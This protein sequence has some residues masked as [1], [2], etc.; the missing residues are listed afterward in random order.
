MKC[1]TNGLKSADNSI[2]REALH[3]DTTIAQRIDLVFS[4]NALMPANHSLML[5]I[6]NFLSK[7]VHGAM[8][9]V[10]SFLL[11]QNL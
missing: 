5:Q 2:L 6:W 10:L 8:R 7:Q 4:T 9:Q 1:S 3:P 11:Y